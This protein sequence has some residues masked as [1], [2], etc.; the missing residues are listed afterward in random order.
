M[1][2]NAKKTSRAKAP[3]ASTTVSP[4]VKQVPESVYEAIGEETEWI[5]ALR[6]EALELYEKG[7]SL[8][9]IC[10]LFH[11]WHQPVLH[12]QVRDWLQYYGSPSALHT[13]K[14]GVVD[15]VMR[16]I[17]GSGGRIS[18]ADIQEMMTSD[19]HVSV[20]PINQHVNEWLLAIEESRRNV[21]EWIENSVLRN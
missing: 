14:Y 6:M 4:P 16:I 5:A 1:S 8:E 13:Y 9:E 20:R 19:Y 10:Y 11:N 2:R 21:I 3:V 18:L 17:A 12:K 7:D 15:C